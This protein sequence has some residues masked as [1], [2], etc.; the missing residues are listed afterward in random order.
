[1]ALHSAQV[2]TVAAAVLLGVYRPKGPYESE[3]CVPY[4][5]VSGPVVAFASVVAAQWA[6]D[7]VPQSR[8]WPG[9]VIIVVIPGLLDL[10]LGGAQWYM[11][12]RVWMTVQ[13]WS[14]AGTAHRL[15]PAHRDRYDL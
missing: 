2:A 5:F 1:V 8:A 6:A 14:G 10:I 11:V 12:V 9:T 4:F 7:A 3:F 15:A 13:R